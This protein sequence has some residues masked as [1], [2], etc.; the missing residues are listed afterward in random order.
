MGVIHLDEESYFTLIIIKSHTPYA[1]PARGRGNAV[2]GNVD[3]R[4]VARRVGFAPVWLPK[5]T[6]THEIANS[7]EGK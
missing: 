3:A 2:Q 5:S 1:N 6:A 7:C 4:F